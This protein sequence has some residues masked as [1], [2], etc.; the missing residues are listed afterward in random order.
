MVE[1]TLS[2]IK[3]PVVTGEPQG[4][5]IVTYNDA[6]VVID[7]ACEE[8]TSD[9][10]N[11]GFG[12]LERSKW[13]L[14]SLQGALANSVGIEC[15]SE[16]VTLDRITPGKLTENGVVLETTSAGASGYVTVT[17]KLDN[18]LPGNGM[19]AVTFPEGFVLDAGE[20]TTAELLRPNSER[21]LEDAEVEVIEHVDGSEKTTALIIRSGSEPFA[22]N[23]PVK[24]KLT[25][26]RN[27]Q[28]SGL[29][30]NFEIRTS[31][32]E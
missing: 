3:N 14:L 22:E 24:V 32:G 31:V 4:G 10:R 9:I 23:Q 19:I 26:I 30:Q 5:G 6:E 27:P 16:T 12:I 29:T 7:G 15:A 1:L 11:R 2:A 18:P 20:D 13:R 21:V 28:V 17:F 8:A 25:N